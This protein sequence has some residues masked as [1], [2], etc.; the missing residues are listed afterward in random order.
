L[1][2]IQ[3]YGLKTRVNINMDKGYIKN[4]IEQNRIKSMASSNKSNY[5]SISQ[6]AQNLGGEIIKNVQSVAAGNPL[7]ADDAEGNRRKSI[8]NSCEFFNKEGDRCT[9]CGCFMAVKA[10]LKASTCPIGKW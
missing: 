3:L 1:I 4:A 10:Y 9:K 8:C 7:S 6:M 2:V 5:P